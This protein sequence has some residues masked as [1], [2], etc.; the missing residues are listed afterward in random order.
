MT[1][2]E[3][4]KEHGN[5]RSGSDSSA[6]LPA[7]PDSG[8]SSGSVAYEACPLDGHSHDWRDCPTPELLPLHADYTYA[9]ADDG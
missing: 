4:S 5:A 6:Q 1:E 7:T 9:E 8:V 2:R 3:L